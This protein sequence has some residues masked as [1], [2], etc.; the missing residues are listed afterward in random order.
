LRRKVPKEEEDSKDPIELEAEVLLKAMRDSNVP[1]FL[2]QDLPLFFG[3]IQ[4]LFPGKNVPLDPHEAVR[5][6]VYRE[7][8]KRDLQRPEGFMLKIIQLLGNLDRETR[9]HDCR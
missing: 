9:S 6:A 2:H 1:K 5:E 7:L 4:D 8:E 3:I